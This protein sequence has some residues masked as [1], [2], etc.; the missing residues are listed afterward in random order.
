MTNEQ[1]LSQLI[2][3]ETDRI[4]Q[5]IVD[6]N[7]EEPPESVSGSSRGSWTT[8]GCALRG[9]LHFARS[10][11]ALAAFEVVT[12]GD[13]ILPMSLADA[14]ALLVSFDETHAEQD[15]AH[16]RCSDAL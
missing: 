14:R 10:V 2:T 13:R 1:P 12:S 5:V 4:S 3:H 11:R 15:R 9:G 6:S 7:Q 8:L 16:R